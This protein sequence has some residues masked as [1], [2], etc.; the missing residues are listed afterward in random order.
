[1]VFARAGLSTI[2]NS[3]EPLTL[4]CTGRNEDDPGAIL[5]QNTGGFRNFHVIAHQDGNLGVRRMVD[6]TSAEARL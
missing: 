4:V 3:A 1:M 2:A 6:I 5:G